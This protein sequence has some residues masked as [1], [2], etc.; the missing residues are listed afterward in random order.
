METF[1][2]RFNGLTYVKLE[3]FPIIFFGDD[4]NMEVNI[5]SEMGYTEKKTV[6]IGVLGKINIPQVGD[7]FVF[8]GL[9][10]YIHSVDF[11]LYR[12]FYKCQTT[13]YTSFE[14]LEDDIKVYEQENITDIES[15]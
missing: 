8:N 1:E 7:F 12:K 5:G 15:I 14:E 3:E 2:G 10:Y 6:N 4:Y 9:V 13:I 11:D